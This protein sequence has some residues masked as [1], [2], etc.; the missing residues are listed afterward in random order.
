MTGR[1]QRRRNNRFESILATFSTLP[2]RKLW[3]IS[4][5]LVNR[6]PVWHFHLKKDGLFG[7]PVSQDD[8]TSNWLLVS[9]FVNSLRRIDSIWVYWITLNGHTKDKRDCGLDQEELVRGGTTLWIK[10]Y[11]LR[12]L[13]HMHKP[14]SLLFSL[15]LTILAWTGENDVKTIVWAKIFCF[16]FFK[17]KMETFEN[18]LV[19]LGPYIRS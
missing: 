8:I 6:L 9:Q 14:R 5:C 10:W 1:H 16:V 19:W 4:K 18:A 15:F 17:M 12:L 7:F 11:Y 3:N 2:H 13:S